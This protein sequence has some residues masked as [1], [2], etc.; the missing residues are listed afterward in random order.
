MTTRQI[1]FRRLV[2]EAD[3]NWNRDR[4]IVDEYKFSTGRVFKGDY[5]KRGAYEETEE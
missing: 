2:V 3:P 5:T 1:D 4:K